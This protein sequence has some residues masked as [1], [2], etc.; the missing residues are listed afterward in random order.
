[1]IMNG[2]KKGS[3][4]KLVIQFCELSKMLVHLCVDPFSTQDGKG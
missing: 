3:S 1:M 4:K 2:S